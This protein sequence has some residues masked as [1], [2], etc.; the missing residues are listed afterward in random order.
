MSAPTQPSQP[1][2]PPEPLNTRSAHNVSLWV[3][4]N[5][6]KGRLK[7]CWN[8][9]ID[10]VELRQEEDGKLVDSGESYFIPVCRHQSFETRF[11]VITDDQLE[12]ML[13]YNLQS[14][15]IWCPK[16]CVYYQ[17]RKWH[18]IRFR[19]SRFFS[20]LYSE[21]RGVVKGFTGLAWQTQ[22]LIV[23]LL[24]LVIT[25]KW[26]PQLLSIIKAIK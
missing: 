26:V 6:A 9:D 12:S 15:P 3:E 8:L 13:R 5:I 22:A 7:R 4:N 1:S 17:N 21:V 23:I 10:K 25:P 18:S 2:P 14:D 19:T 16:Q 11:G 20:G 24:I